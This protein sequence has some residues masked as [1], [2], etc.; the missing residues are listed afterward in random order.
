MVMSKVLGGGRSLSLLTLK[1]T[2]EMQPQETLTAAAASL[3]HCHCRISAAAAETRSA[4]F[5][6]SSKSSLF[7]VLETPDPPPMK[8]D[9]GGL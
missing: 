4:K 7:R 8:L 2:P 1:P 5:A 9:S 3:G 6:A